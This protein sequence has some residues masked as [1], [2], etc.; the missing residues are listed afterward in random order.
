MTD[1]EKLDEIQ[2]TPIAGAAPADNEAL[3]ISRDEIVSLLRAAFIYIDRTDEAPA[4]ATRLRE[5]IKKLEVNLV[6]RR[7]PEESLDP[8]AH[9]AAER[10]QDHYYNF[11]DG[12][13]AKYLP[14]PGHAP[15]QIIADAKGR[16]LCLARNEHTADLICN[17]INF[18]VLATAQAQADGKLPAMAAEPGCAPEDRP[19]I[20]LP[21][22]AGKIIPIK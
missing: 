19:R 15:Q 13:L 2:R 3:P 7:T 12:T 18:L 10:E 22:G 20:V 17:G 1:Q 14:R 4:L 11:D 9:A 8:E 21:P 16:M 5:T 6:R